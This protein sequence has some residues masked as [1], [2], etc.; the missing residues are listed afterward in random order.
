MMKPDMN[1]GGVFVI[2]MGDPAH[3]PPEL[4]YF[5][6]EPKIPSDVKRQRKFL[7]GFFD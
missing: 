3:P 1:F 5:P 4:G 6:Y 7:W 2:I